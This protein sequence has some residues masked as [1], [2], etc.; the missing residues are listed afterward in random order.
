MIPNLMNPVAPEGP[1]PE[2]P[3]EQRR[4]MIHEALVKSL[5][6]PQDNSKA[7]AANEKSAQGMTDQAQLLRAG[8]ILGA[9]FLGRQSNGDNL[10]SQGLDA[11]AKGLLGKNLEM[12]NQTAEAEKRRAEI[13]KA[14]GMQDVQDAAQLDRQNKNNVDQI[15]R[16]NNQNEHTVGRDTAKFGQEEKM[17]GVNHG[18]RMEELGLQNKGK[19]DAKGV[20]GKPLPAPIVDKLAGYDLA[21][22]SSKSMR[23]YMIEKGIK[24]GKITTMYQDFAKNFGTNSPEYARF[25]AESGANL[26]EYIRAMSGAATSDTER[27]DLKKNTPN[28]DDSPESFAAKAEWFEEYVNKKRG[29]FLDTLKKSNYD[30]SKFDADGMQRPEQAQK[31]LV[32]KQ[33]NRALNKTRF[34]YSDGSEEIKDGLQ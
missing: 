34:F 28:A 13:A 11:D 2:T 32:R 4:R 24:P 20:N 10:G 12:K 1:A 30:T 5:S 27:A 23:D 33:Q 3:E 8:N 19:V 15:T 31:T 17:A 14:F 7:I 22:A 6:A 9:A 26:A 25:Q 16:D 29:I 21:L 18:Y